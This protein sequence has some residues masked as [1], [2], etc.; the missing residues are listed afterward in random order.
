MRALSI[1]YF[2]KNHAEFLYLCCTISVGNRRLFT[3]R[4]C[5]KYLLRRDGANFIFDILSE[6][7]YASIVRTRISICDLKFM[8]MRP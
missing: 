8:V 1:F 2:V 5:L 6:I 3:V 4:K 7:I